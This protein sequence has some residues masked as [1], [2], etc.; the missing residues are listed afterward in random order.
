MN[1]LKSLFITFTL[2]SVFTPLFTAAQDADT[3]RHIASR[4]IRHEQ[5]GE[6]F[7]SLPWLNP[8]I[9][10]WQHNYSISS[11]ETT[12][13]Q[14]KSPVDIRKG[15]QEDI[16]TFDAQTYM[17]HQSSTLWGRAFY[18]NGRTRN[19]R[20]NETSDV[21]VVAPY[22][23]ADSVGGKRLNI[24]RYSFSGGYA[25]HNSRF[26]WG[27]TVGYTAGLYYRNVDPRPRNVT[28]ELNIAAGAAIDVKG[29]DIAAALLFKKYK[30]TNN[31]AFYS[32]LGNE[33]LFHLTGPTT[34]YARFAGTAYNTYYKGQQ[35]S[36]TL[37][38]IPRDKSGLALTFEASRFALDNV[39]TT[40]NKLP[41]AHLTLNELTAEVAWLKQEIKLKTHAKT[42]RRVGTENIFGDPAA[43][44]Y[45]KIGELNMYFENRFNTGIAALWEAAVTQR[46]RI[47]LQPTIDYNH[48]NTL[49]VDPYCRRLI[50]DFAYALKVKT[51][52]SVR[53]T[54]LTLCA[55]AIISDPV[56]SELTLP[57]SNL[58]L[59]GLQRAVE[60]NFNYLAH[61]RTTLAA[62]AQA[63]FSLN[64][65][66]AIK[67]A[68]TYRHAA[69]TH[70]DKEQFFLAAVGV[71]F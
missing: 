21:E 52:Y 51:D 60:S 34:D 9:K 7:L 11:V 38:L 12:F 39:L 55:W 32:E 2:A 58:E 16:I 5:L 53:R 65:K 18:H 30:Q 35:W 59:S 44:V 43:S 46:V 31:V 24:E 26:S 63:F 15:D 23:L 33:K 36:A 27:A 4:L 40:F 71:C 22:M 14:A 68:L 45:P 56:K 28:A 57:Q 69:L 42:A 61:T 48:S 29:F 54:L 41:M 1:R 6:H 25:D 50:N 3:T 62:Q 10:Q 70:S 20:W 47:A 13:S 19:M 37:N 64:S 17:K 67:L 49:Y 66:Y 8:A